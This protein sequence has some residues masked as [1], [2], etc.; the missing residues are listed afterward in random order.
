MKGIPRSREK[1]AVEFMIGKTEENLFYFT[2]HLPLYDYNSDYTMLIY[3][4]WKVLEENTIET[5]DGTV[6]EEP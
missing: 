1:T 5:I 3:T 2:G 4:Q 6:T